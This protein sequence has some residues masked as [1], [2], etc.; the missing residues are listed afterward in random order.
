MAWGWSFLHSDAGTG[1]TPTRREGKL[2]I[3]HYAKHHAN[4]G[5]ETR[6]HQFDNTSGS[7][8]PTQ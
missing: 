6:D 3:Q 1:S 8:T 4:D 5:R 2:F 7:T